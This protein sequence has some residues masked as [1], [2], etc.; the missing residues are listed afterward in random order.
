MVMM[1]NTDDSGD[2]FLHMVG[3]LLMVVSDHKEVTTLMLIVM[4]FAEM[5]SWG[6]F[7]QILSTKVDSA[8]YMQ[9]Y[10]MAQP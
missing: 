1:S 9:L 3:D 2:C 6:M 4:L 8:V 7:I 10:L 5:Q